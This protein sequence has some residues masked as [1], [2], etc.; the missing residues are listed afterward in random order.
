MSYVAI[1]GQ[2]MTEYVVLVETI[3]TT[4]TKGG[5]K[6]LRE[7]HSQTPWCWQM[8]LTQLASSA[9]LVATVISYLSLRLLSYPAGLG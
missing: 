7:M 2:L 1:H 4:G 5:N 9:V 3:F 8:L 6:V